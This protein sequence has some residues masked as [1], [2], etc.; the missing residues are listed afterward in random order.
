MIRNLIVIDNNSRPIVSANF[1]ECHSLGQDDELI[2]GFISAV[3][4]FS[5]MLAADSLDQIQMRGLTF[6]IKS[7]GTLIFALSADDPNRATHEKTLV[8]IIDLFEDL[9][10]YYSTCVDPDVDTSV[11]HE[12]PRFLVDQSILQPN[13]GKYTDCKDCPNSERDLPLRELTKELDKRLD[14]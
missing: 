8:K 12:F 11:F 1:G 14:A 6:I 7:R 13:C 2:S 4:S 5:K 3:Y 9:Y 10:D